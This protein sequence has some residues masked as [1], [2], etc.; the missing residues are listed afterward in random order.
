MFSRFGRD[1]KPDAKIAKTIA[2]A[3][4]RYATPG[5]RASLLML[6]SHPENILLGQFFPAEFTHDSFISQ[7]VCP[8]TDGNK[9]R[10]FRTDHKNCGAV[11]DQGFHELVNLRLRSD[12]DA[13]CR[14]I[15]D[16]ESRSRIQPLS[17]HD[18]L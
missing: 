11:G 4:S 17:D 13:A 12:I 10:K 2:R 14:L 9:F 15:E 5:T 6:H 1:A 3:T 8:I 7:D 18:F 16:E